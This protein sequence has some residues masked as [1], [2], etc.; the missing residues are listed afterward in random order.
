M[1]VV[2]DENEWDLAVFERVAHSWHHNARHPASRR[3][4]RCE[5]VVPDRLDSIQMRGDC[6]QQQGGIVVARVERQPSGWTVVV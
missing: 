4:K 6:A 5:D 3:R 2:Q 1:Q